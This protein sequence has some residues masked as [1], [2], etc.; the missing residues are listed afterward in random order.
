MYVV[1]LIYS[2][3]ND[4]WDVAQIEIMRLQE[5]GKVIYYQLYASTY[6]N[7]Q[8]RTFV[9]VIQDDFMRITTSKFSCN[10]SWA[11]DSTFNTNQYGFPSLCR[12]YDRPRW[13]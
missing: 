8:R 12:H 9:V 13:N 6:E 2:L 5:Q 10:N 4:D 1:I 7:P 11:L 3:C